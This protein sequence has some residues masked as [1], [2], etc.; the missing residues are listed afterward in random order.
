MIQFRAT[1]VRLVASAVLSSG[2]GC[3]PGLRS[4]HRADQQPPVC[5]RLQFGPWSAAY[6]VPFAQ[7]AAG[8]VSP[9][10]DTIAL[11]ARVITRYGRAYNVA[12]K[13]PP[14]SMA[15]AGTWIRIGRDTLVLDLPSDARVGLRIRLL[16]SGEEL[17]GVAGV[18]FLHP[19]F[20][21]KNVVL[22][23]PIDPPAPWAN[24]TALRVACASTFEISPPGA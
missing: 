23:D 22:F 21:G 1:A 19:E 12:M 3:Q 7:A 10:P 17:Q 4:T 9:L 20:E 24:V 15:P 2:A 13:A 16:G 5:Y 14:D 18:L 11:T 8:L 6:Q